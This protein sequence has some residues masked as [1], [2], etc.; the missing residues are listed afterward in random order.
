MSEHNRLRCGV[1]TTD[2]KTRP[3]DKLFRDVRSKGFESVQFSFVSASECGYEPDGQLEIP[4][5]VPDSAINAILSASEKYGLPIAAVN[6]T[7][8]MAHPDK[9]VRDEGIRRFSGFA[10]A[11][12][13]LGAPYISLCSGTRYRAQLWTYSPENRTADAWRD[14]ADSMKRAVEIAERLDVTL[15]IETEASNVIDSPE[16]ARRVM[17]EIGSAKLKMILDCANLFHRGTARPENVRPTIAHAFEL[18]G[19]DIVI[20]HGKD[21]KAGDGI[22]FCGTGEGIVDFA[23]TASLLRK[24]NFSGDMFLHGIYDE[25]KMEDALKHWKN[26]E[27]E[28]DLK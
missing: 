10:A 5:E 8:N 14:M 12:K 22:D 28:E 3:A 23:Y 4:G 20:A 2:F 9:E 1:C 6:G 27:I 26:A 15:A 21:I 16:A 11:V 19:G 13:R 18:F 7:F 17:D 25:D 24:H